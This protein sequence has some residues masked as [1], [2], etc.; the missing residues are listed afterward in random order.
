MNI[1]IVHEPHEISIFELA[2]AAD[3]LFGAA[4]VLSTRGN[5]EGVVA[6][7]GN[8]GMESMDRAPNW[9]FVGS[10][11]GRLYVATNPDGR[12]ENVRLTELLYDIALRGRER[13]AA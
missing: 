4:Y 9:L 8:I 11:D 12:T 2:D 1:S 6:A 13:L 5:A 7:L 3:Q 10:D